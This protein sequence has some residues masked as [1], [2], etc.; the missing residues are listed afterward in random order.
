MIS[1]TDP[2]WHDRHAAYCDAFD[3]TKRAIVLDAD[4]PQIINER[5]NPIVEEVERMFPA[6]EFDDGQV[7]GI[8]DAWTEG[9]IEALGFMMGGGDA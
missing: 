3:A 9:K 6:N 2:T 4:L 8:V 1:D 5:G 7:S